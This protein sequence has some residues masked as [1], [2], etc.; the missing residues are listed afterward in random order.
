MI[1]TPELQTI[2]MH[3]L[4]NLPELILTFQAGKGDSCFLQ[5]LAKE[6]KFENH[7]T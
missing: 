7:V 6:D 3:P 1:N 4:I 5:K 2:E